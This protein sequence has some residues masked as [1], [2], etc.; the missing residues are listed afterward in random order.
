M[1]VLFCSVLLYYGCYGIPAEWRVPLALVTYV[2]YIIGIDATAIVVFVLFTVW[3]EIESEFEIDATGDCSTR[4]IAVVEAIA[5]GDDQYYCGYRIE[6]HHHWHV[7][8]QHQHDGIR[9]LFCF[10]L[11]TTVDGIGDAMQSQ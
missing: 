5:P 3:E 7:S 10:V 2:K 6:K 4:R 11:V 1:D 8:Q 9:I